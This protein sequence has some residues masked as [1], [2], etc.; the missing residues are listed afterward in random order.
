MIKGNFFLSFTR[1]GVPEG[2]EVIFLLV[3]A[4]FPFLPAGALLLTPDNGAPGL[5]PVSQGLALLD[6]L[7]LSFCYDVQ[8]PPLLLLQLL[9]LS[10][11]LFVQDAPQL[12][13]LF[14]DPVSLRFHLILKEHAEKKEAASLL[15]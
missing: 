6:Q 3:L 7:Y 4:P 1:I 11:L 5:R 2:K 12:I 9:Q 8:P 14:L 13:K 15:S 10:L